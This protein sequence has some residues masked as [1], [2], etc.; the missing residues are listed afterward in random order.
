[1]LKKDQAGY[2]KGWN[3]A[4]NVRGLLNAWKAFKQKSIN[5]LVVSLNAEKTFDQ[6]ERSFNSLGV[7]F[8]KWVKIRHTRAQAA[9]LTEGF[10]EV[11]ILT[12][13]WC[14]SARYHPPV[15]FGQRAT[16]WGHKGH[17]HNMLFRDW[18]AVSQNN[19]ICTQIRAI[20]LRILHRLHIS[21]Q[22]RH[23][24]KRPLFQL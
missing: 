20:Q 21:P 24:F 2:I 13:G 22:H 9:V 15:S 4:T 14:S 6:I 11:W 5:V 8:I 23:F 1:M 16:C 10:S 3:S 12:E 18:T 19:L 17:I 7:N